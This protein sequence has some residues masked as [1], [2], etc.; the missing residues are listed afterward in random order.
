LEA[1]LDYLLAAKRFPIE[2]TDERLPK[3]FAL[4]MAT[5]TR[6]ACHMR[7]RPSLDVL[8]LPEEILRRLYGGPVDEQFTSYSGKGRMVWWHEL[9]NAVSDSLGFCRFLTVFSSPHAPQYRD[10]SKWITLS[11]GLTFTPGELRTIGERIYTL[12]RTML[13]KEGFS[14]RDDTL[15]RRYFEEPVPEGPAKGAVILR[16]EFERMLDE[17]YQLHGWDLNG[18]PKKTTLRRLGIGP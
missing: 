16:D 4:G 7:S 2:M 14:R 9:L 17:Y 13:I 1:S 15:P 11:T 18:L 3:S 5:S 10:F 12:E 6:G 8:G